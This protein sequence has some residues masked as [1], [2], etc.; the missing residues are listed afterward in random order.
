MPDVR[1]R[2]EDRT[3][4]ERYYVRFKGRVLGPMS[5]DKT[6]ELIRRGQISRMHE[7]S[8]DGLAWRP[9]EEFTELFPKKVEPA[10]QA[11]QQAKKDA[12]PVAQPAEQWYA[13]IDGQNVGP[14]EEDELRMLAASGR[15]LP[16]SL[17]W[18][19]GMS[20]WL[21]A[22]V[23][24]PTWFARTG[25][26]Q[27][28]TGD[29]LNADTA[30]S[31]SEICAVTANR[32]FWVYLISICGIVFG[33]LGIIVH[34]YSLV[35]QVFSPADS[36]AIVKLVFTLI[37]IA[38]FGFTEFCFV[39]LLR[40]ANSISLLRHVQTVDTLREAARR[41]S[42]FWLYSGLFVLS[43]I[44]MFFLFTL[45]AVA[46]GAKLSYLLRDFS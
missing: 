11:A 4:E 5:K 27:S 8:P 6:I 20:E 3:L 17:I 24:K 42:S 46:V 44:I 45:F 37:M 38:V 19:N 32:S 40:Y 34:V 10:P 25:R 16:D 18:K 15:L 21:A 43:S 23:L 13:H 14:I 30:A 29:Q 33:G 28:T 36:G 26:S 12:A 35:G 31:I 39:T 7:L 9:A 41:L 1:L 22:E 2:L